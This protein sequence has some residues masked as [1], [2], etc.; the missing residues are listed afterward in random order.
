VALGVQAAQPASALHA[1]V[2]IT[3]WAVVLLGVA[4]PLLVLERLERRDH[5]LAHRRRGQQA[6]EVDSWHGTQ[7]SHAPASQLP[8][9]QAGSPGRLW[10]LNLLLLSCLS[11]RLACLAQHVLL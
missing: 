8:A 7:G 6:Q 9:A 10:G 1:C 4:L 2:S 11:W 5:K 3:N